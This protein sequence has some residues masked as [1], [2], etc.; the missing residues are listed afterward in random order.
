MNRTPAALLAASAAAV[1][2]A[3]GCGSSKSDGKPSTPRATAGD[4]AGTFTALAAKVPSAKLG[5]IV[6]ADSDPNHLLGRPG[7]YTSKVTFTDTRV[8]PGDTDGLDA[9]DVSRG[10]AI[11]QFAKPDEAAAR[12]QYIQAVTK[13]MAALAEYDYVHDTA[14]IRVS[15][16]LTP[17]QAGEYETAAKNLP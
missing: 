11:E 16:Y 5:G 12:A 2:L 13:G 4:A 8:K 9:D 3:T 15:H 7:Q 6:T 14:V 10:G 1:L 17:A